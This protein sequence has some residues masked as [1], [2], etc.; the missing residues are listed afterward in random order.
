MTRIRYREYTD[1]NRFFK[2]L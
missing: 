1:K 2:V